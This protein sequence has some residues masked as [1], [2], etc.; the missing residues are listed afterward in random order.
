MHVCMDASLFHMKITASV[1]KRPHQ[2]RS[3]CYLYLH[4]PVFSFTY[5]PLLRQNE[6]LLRSQFSLAN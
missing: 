1:T 5:S 3:P 4:L 6:N 2:D